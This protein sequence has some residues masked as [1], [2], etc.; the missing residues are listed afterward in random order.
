MTF[1]LS[2][3]LIVAWREPGCSLLAFVVRY[4]EMKSYITTLLE[5]SSR[6]HGRFI[7]ML[8]VVYSLPWCSINVNVVISDVKWFALSKSLLSISRL[9]SAD[10]DQQCQE[11]VVEIKHCLFVSYN[12]RLNDSIVLPTLKVCLNELINNWHQTTSCRII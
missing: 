4:L 11:I 7:L 6:C 3:I 9:V 8:D 5:S 12:S 2:F 10:V 1:M